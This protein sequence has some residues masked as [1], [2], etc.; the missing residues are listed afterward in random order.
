MI[1]ETTLRGARGLVHLTLQIKHFVTRNDTPP[2]QLEIPLARAAPYLTHLD[3]SCSHFVNLPLAISGLAS[4]QHLDMSYNPLQL[5]QACLEVVMSLPCLRVLEMRKE[6][7]DSFSSLTP[8]SHL[9]D[10]HS[11]ELIASIRELLPDLNVQL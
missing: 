2:C 3:L 1:S 9:W 6:E 5:Q 8:W 10:T 4:L 11:M 7:R